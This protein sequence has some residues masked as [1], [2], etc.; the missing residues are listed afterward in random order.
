MY[1]LKRL[2]ENVKNGKLEDE[3][4]TKLF[5]LKASFEKLTNNVALLEMLSMQVS[6]KLSFKALA[7][8]VC[9]VPSLA[10]F[11]SLSSCFFLFLIFIDSVIK[12]C[13][14]MCVQ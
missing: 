11:S 5:F 12:I 8:C 7:K 3:I 10:S 2:N 13:V 1:K 14:C 9:I 4:L 6:T